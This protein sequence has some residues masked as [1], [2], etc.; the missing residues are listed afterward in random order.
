V[1]VSGQ[2]IAHTMPARAEIPVVTGWGVWGEQPG[3]PPN[4]MYA[5]VLPERSHA[6]G[7]AE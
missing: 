1:P 6:E 7:M 3:A 4:V 2:D 5:T